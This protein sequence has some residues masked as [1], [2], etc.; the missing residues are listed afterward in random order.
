MSV[1]NCAGLAWKYKWYWNKKLL[2]FS[3]SVSLKM[4]EIWALVPYVLVL[5][6][7]VWLALRVL[8]SWPSILVNCSLV[9]LLQ[10]SFNCEQVEK[11]SLLT[12][13]LVIGLVAGASF[14]LEL[15]SAEIILGPGIGKT[16][17]LGWTVLNGD[18]GEEWPL[19]WI[20]LNCHEVFGR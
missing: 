16:V 9:L 3:G 20:H 12:V 18:L 15:L 14:Q 11:V 8:A 2:S 13:K 19:W 6:P 4:S 1:S 7:R 10:Q 17:W 5:G